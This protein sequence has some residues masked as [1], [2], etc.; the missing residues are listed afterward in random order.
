MSIEKQLTTKFGD[1]SY[2]L[3]SGTHVYLQGDNLL[4]HGVRYNVSVHLRLV[5]GV[6]TVDYKNVR[7]HD[8]KNWSWPAHK[9]LSAA[10]QEAWEKEITDNPSLLQEAAVVDLTSK[11]KSKEDEIEECKEKLI[12]KQMELVQLHGD[13]AKLTS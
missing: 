9:Q 12:E 5:D 8:W 13:L 10:L 6:W 7:R 4:F 3:T 1:F 11:I 2:C